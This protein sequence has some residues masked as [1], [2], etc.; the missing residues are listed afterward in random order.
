MRVTPTRFGTALLACDFALAAAGA[1]AQE[2][3]SVHSLL[4]RPTLT[5]DWFG[6]GDAMR[7][8]GV[9]LR[10][11]WSQYYQGFVDGDGDK[12]WDY[13]GKLDALLLLD[14][15][16]MGLWEGLS[17][18]AQ[19]HLNHGQNVNNLGGS[20]IPANTALAFPGDEDADYADVMALFVTQSIGERVAISAGKFNML[21]GA[22]ATLLQGGGGVDTFWNTGLAAPITGLVPPTIFGARATV[23][24]DPMSFALFV[25]D[26]TDATNHDV[27]DDPFEKG[28]TTMGVAALRTAIGGRTGVYGVRGIYST[29]EG[30]DLRDIAGL[31]LPPEAEDI[32]TEKGAFY[33]GLTMRQHLFQSESNPAVG[34][35]VFG[36]IGI[37]DGNPNPLDWVGYVGVGGSSP[38]PGRELD[39]FGVAYFH[40]GISEDLKDGLEPIADLEDESG[41]E[42]FY[43]WAATPWLRITGDIQFI[44]PGRGAF[45]DDIFTGLS[46]SIRF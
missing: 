18:T 41:M 20:L 9:H 32:R 24:A 28:V 3:P 30:I 35:G 37:S 27:F 12:D 31:V 2:A 23:R 43:N 16:R 40:Y 7:D 38:I 29:K 14:L 34:W 26:P 36:E 33:V 13:G 22:R 5:D 4:N 42:V 15:S 8:A 10:L 25:F 21:E 1:A 44:D 19:G 45:A 46:T 6:Q 11:E 17:V 39:R